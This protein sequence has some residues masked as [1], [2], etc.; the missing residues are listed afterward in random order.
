MPLSACDKLSTKS[1]ARCREWRGLPGPPHSAPSVS[2][3][4]NRNG[5]AHTAGGATTA[6]GGPAL[7]GGQQIASGHQQDRNVSVDITASTN[8]RQPW[9]RGISCYWES[10]R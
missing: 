7:L 1:F 6:T 10:S 8:F 3:C 2:T 5:E 4:P 9:S